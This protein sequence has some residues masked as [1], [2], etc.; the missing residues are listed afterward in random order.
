[1]RPING[2]AR[3]QQLLGEKKR[4]ELEADLERLLGFKLKNIT[5]VVKFDMIRII[6]KVEEMQERIREL[7]KENGI[8]IEEKCNEKKV[9]REKSKGH[10]CSLCKE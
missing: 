9:P 7:E 1:M 3:I 2:Y 10:M 5:Y 4:P 6:H 8:I